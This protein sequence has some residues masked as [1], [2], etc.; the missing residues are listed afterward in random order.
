MDFEKILQFIINH[1]SE[2]F[3]VLG[4]TL[5]NPKLKYPAKE[6]TEPEKNLIYIKNKETKID[7]NINPK[8]FEFAFISVFIGSTLQTLVPRN[9]ASQQLIT[10]VLVPLI[11][12]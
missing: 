1:L 2:Y 9:E 10:V 5:K 4:S 3:T 6:P 7:Q 8:L 11:A 12:W